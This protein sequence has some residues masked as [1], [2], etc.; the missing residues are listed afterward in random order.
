MADGVA[1]CRGPEMSRP[2][3]LSVPSII[4]LII[5]SVAGLAFFAWP[6]VVPATASRQATASTPYFFV[7]IVGLI[8][9]L[10]LIQVTEEGLDAKALAMLGVLSAV[11]AALRPLS[12]GTNGIELG[13][14]LLILAGRV[15]GPGFGFLLG[16]TSIFASALLTAGI[17]P[18]LPFQMLAAAW[19][20]LG[21]GL[22]PHRLGRKEM[23]IA[24]EII[25]LVVYGIVSAYLFGA[26]MNLWF[27]PFMTGYGD[28]TLGYVPGGSL[29]TNL[30][31]FLVY[32]LAT[33]TIVWDTGRAITNI[34][35]IV[36]LGPGVLGILRRA[37]RRAA[38]SS[39]QSANMA[40]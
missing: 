32:T 28:N 17:G 6:L 23:S 37:A 15:F 9:L 13:F 12:A 27:W 33:S 25:V 4:T 10:T 20:G 29:A 31:H 11:G 16:C 19:V 35:L 26:L 3:P 36:S 38:F 18:W 21:A 39:G 24:T 7:V 22:L 34:A 14:F 2:V 40:R 1:D 5:A 8:I 30:H